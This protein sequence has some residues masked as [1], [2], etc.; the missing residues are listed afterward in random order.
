[1]AG[2]C[3]LYV[4]LLSAERPCWS[5]SETDHVIVY[6]AD[7]LALAASVLYWCVLEFLYAQNF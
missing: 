1:V 6:V 5:V 4:S 7:Y 2:P 3:E